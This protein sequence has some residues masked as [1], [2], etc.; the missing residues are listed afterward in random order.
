[1]I[2]ANKTTKWCEHEEVL[3]LGSSMGS[4]MKNRDAAHCHKWGCCEEVKKWADLQEKMS[5][6][7]TQQ[8]EFRT[9]EEC[10]WYHVLQQGI[11]PSTC[12]D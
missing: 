5:A 4:N 7:Q 9:G 10:R 2:P 6:V 12:S 3:A 1:M 8:G 11:S